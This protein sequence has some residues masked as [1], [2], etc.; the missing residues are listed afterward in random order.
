VN[1][2]FGSL[3]LNYE[4]IK[5]PNNNYLCVGRRLFNAN[6]FTALGFEIGGVNNPSQIDVVVE[7]DVNSGE[8][9][10]EWNIKDHVIQ[11]R[12]ANLNNYGVIAD[13]PE[14]LD[15]DALSTYDWTFTESFM[16]NGMDY[17]PELDQIALSVRKMSEVI[18]IDHS[19]TT[20]E[21]ASHNGGNSGKRW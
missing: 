19:T 8:I 2:P 10:W 3:A 11:E 20:A 4:V 6:D 14:L 18:I 12:D 1:I 9:V 17:N 5:L 16:I 15:M 7:V 13:H 21:A